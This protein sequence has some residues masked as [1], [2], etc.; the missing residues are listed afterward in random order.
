MGATRVAPRAQE[1]ALGQ[2]HTANYC[3]ANLQTQPACCDES[4]GQTLGK[5]RVRPQSPARLGPEAVV[6]RDQS[7][8]CALTLGP[9]T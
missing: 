9:R 1:I 2:R 6:S 5:C 4:A 8:K 3:D 7:A